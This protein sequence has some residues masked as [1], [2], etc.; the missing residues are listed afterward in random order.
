MQVHDARK[1]Q[2]V[3]GVEP[4]GAPGGGSGRVVD[5]A[6]MEAQAGVLDAARRQDALACD[7]GQGRGGVCAC[8]H[9]ATLAGLHYNQM[10]R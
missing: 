10:S 7:T 8:I 3:S 9:D 5:Q 4:G 2:Q 6:A 1:H